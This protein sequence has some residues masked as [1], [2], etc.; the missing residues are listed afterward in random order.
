MG[1]PGSV[2]DHVEDLRGG[3]DRRLSLHAVHCSLRLP[4][5]NASDI[6]LCAGA[7]IPGTLGTDGSFPWASSCVFCLGAILAGFGNK[8]TGK[9]WSC[10]AFRCCCLLLMRSWRFRNDPS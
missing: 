5:T 4:Q 8:G 3:D 10:G 6:E 7:L 2:L 1:L 9:E